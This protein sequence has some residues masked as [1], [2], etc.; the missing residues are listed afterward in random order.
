MYSGIC[1]CK[2]RDWLTWLWGPRGP[3]PAVCKL[4]PQEGWGWDS[5]ES[6]GL[7]TRSSSVSGQERMEVQLQGVNLPFPPCCS[8][9]ALSGWG[10]APH[11]G[12][13]H[14][15]TRMLM[16]LE[17]PSQTHPE[18]IWASL[19][20][21]RLTQKTHHHRLRKEQSPS[22]QTSELQNRTVIRLSCCEPL[23]GHRSHETWR[24]GSSWTHSLARCAGGC[25]GAS[26]AG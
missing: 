2:H 21:V 24:Q 10:A 8:V 5:L 17:T 1:E 11:I 3:G 16:S 9:W 23:C 12:R 13:G 7:G 19:D 26:R 4:E 25:R 18:I 20:S 14:L 6:E 15:C 22:F